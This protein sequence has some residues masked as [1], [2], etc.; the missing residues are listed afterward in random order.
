MPMQQKPLVPNKSDFKYQIDMW[1]ALKITQQI[2]RIYLHL[3][4]TRN[5]QIMVILK[6]K[7][8]LGGYVKPNKAAD[9][10]P[11]QVKK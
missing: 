3:I 7:V 1:E 10:K 2:I 5:H 8:I 9:S 11:T 6:R 4:D